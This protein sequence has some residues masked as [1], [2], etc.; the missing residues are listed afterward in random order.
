VVFHWDNSILRTFKSLLIRPGHFAKEYIDGKRKSFVKPF[1]FFLFFLTVYVL[2]YHWFAG[3]LDTF[4]R[5]SIVPV[6]ALSKA[7]KIM[8]VVNIYFNYLY[9]VFPLAF[10]FILVL[11]LKKKNSVNYAE[12]LVFSFYAFAMVLIF[13]IGIMLLSLLD[14]RIWNLRVVITSIYLVY[15]LMQFSGQAKVKGVAIGVAAV[16]LSYVIYVISVFILIFIY[17]VILAH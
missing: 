14:I 7:E 13:G 5:S 16:L 6:E 11:F 17:F 12:A 4:I 10:A 3:R 8:H 2:L 1:T 9:F 15:A